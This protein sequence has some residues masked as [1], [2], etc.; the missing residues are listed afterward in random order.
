MKKQQQPEGA[1][2]PGSRVARPVRYSDLGGI[3]DVLSDIKELIEYP[4]AHPEVYA[5]L[6]VEPPRGVLLHGPPGC[7]KTALANAIAT[8]CGVPLLRVS[9]PEIVSGMSGESEAKAGAGVRACFGAAAFLTGRPP[10]Q[11]RS[12]FAEALDLAPCIIFIDEIDA[13]ATKRDNAQR[14]MERRIVAQMLTSIDDL[15]AASAQAQ[16]VEGE[17]E[18]GAEATAPAQRK[19]VVVLG[20]TNR[21]DALDPALRRAGRFDREISLGIPTE[22]ARARILEVLCRKLRLDGDFDYKSIAKRT[23]GFVGADLAALAKEAAALAVRRIFDRLEQE[24]KG[25]TTEVAADGGRSGIGLG[26]G[27][28]PAELQSLSITMSD[29]EAA[30]GKVQP[31]VRREGFTTT[32]DV[33]WEDVGSLEGVREELSFAISQPIAHP[34]RFEAMGLPTA[35]GVLLFGPPGESRVGSPAPA[36]CGG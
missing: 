20:A 7:G 2:A 36:S 1:V 32:P 23:P 10:F 33:T 11:I 24:A 22:S 27:L 30:L 15:G 31:S 35:T 21:P 19:H 16:Q 6:G 3:E 12:L 17:E 28:T 9:A 5:W 34:E 13:I 29:F 4:L 8:E 18:G 14:E 25:S 26:R